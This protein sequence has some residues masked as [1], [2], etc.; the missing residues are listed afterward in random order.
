MNRFIRYGLC[1]MLALS[2]LFMTIAG[3][4][5]DPTEN[6]SVSN[7]DSQSSSNTSKEDYTD[8]QSSSVP[9]ETEGLTQTESEA[10]EVQP[11]HYMHSA[12]KSFQNMA[13]SYA[14]VQDSIDIKNK[15]SYQSLGEMQIEDYPIDGVYDQA[16]NCIKVG[17]TYK[18]WW[19]RA[20]PYDTIWYA[21]SKDMKN[22]YNAQC[23]IDLKGY[24]TTWITPAAGPRS[25]RCAPRR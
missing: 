15:Y 10:A 23:V 6:S 5:S 4:T 3:C 24:E 19:G 20:C 9:N 2:C 17:D 12:G 18:M 1:W 25:R 11:D 14:P 21:E 13:F 16:F 7:M 8:E 22:W